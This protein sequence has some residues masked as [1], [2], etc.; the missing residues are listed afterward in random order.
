MER[1]ESSVKNVFAEMAS[2]VEKI[3]PV[4]S[5]KTAITI[6]VLG[7]ETYPK[8]TE[9]RRRNLVNRARR[10]LPLPISLTTDDQ[11][12]RI[13]KQRFRT[14]ILRQNKQLTERERLFSQVPDFVKLML[15]KDP[16]LLKNAFPE[17]YARYTQLITLLKENSV[18]DSQSSVPESSVAPYFPF[19]SQLQNYESTSNLPQLNKEAENQLLDEEYENYLKHHEVLQY[20]ASN[21]NKIHHKQYD[22]EIEGWTSQV[23][24]RNYGKPDPSIAPSKVPCSGC[25]AHLHCAATNV[26]GFMPSEKF[27]LFSKEELASQLCQRCDFLQRYNVALNVTVPADEYPKLM[28]QI[29]LNNSLV[30]ILVDLLDFPCSVWPGIVNLIGEKHSIYLVGNKV[31]LLPKDD[32][33]YLERIKKSLKE[34]LKANGIGRN[35][36]IRDVS[37]ISAKTGYGVENLVTKL[38]RDMRKGE[39]VYLIGCTN[40]GKSTLFN[41][42]MQT[43]L[44]AL[45]NAD[46]MTRATTSL[47]PGTTLNLLKFP[48]KKL[49]GWQMQLRLNRLNLYE[50]KDIAERR[51][52][53]TMY[54]QDE[55]HFP[56]LS[57]RIGATFRNNV[58]VKVEEDHPLSGYSNSQSKA[59]VFNAD[60]RKL[61]GGQWVHDTPGVI[62]KDQLLNL[63]TTEELLRTVPRELITPRTYTL[64]PGQSLF[65]GGLARVDLVQ[66]RQNIWLT[67]FASRYL[68]VNIVYTEQARKFYE[69]YLGTD[70]LAVPMGGEERLEQWPKL[71]PNELTLDCIGWEESCADVVLSNAAWAAVTGGADTRCVLRA[72]TPEGR[73]I[74]VRNPPMLP[75]AVRLRGKRIPNTP[76]FENKLFTI[77]DQT[78]G[79]IDSRMVKYNKYQTK[80]GEKRLRKAVDFVRE[81]DVTRE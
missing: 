81:S 68:P 37:L 78:S 55:S 65:V 34:S 56:I 32:K 8:L 39:D 21:L 38:L 18:N 4:N 50:K 47:W 61:K 1:P 43:D 80:I 16:N 58:P 62:F 31:D 79:A 42:L 11:I 70:M 26:P 54:R 14:S 22:L 3:A 60:S 24:L 33:F 40:S 12:G 29:Q 23:W 20:F 49:A 28:S 25:G 17:I 48:S 13:W 73:G 71:L 63:L 51:L 57:Q 66:A 45:D 59:K 6:D 36:K 19:L 44:C 75:F 9:W 76:C 72:F 41:M 64:R 46:L 35:A 5:Q 74:Y 15:E 53:W 77:D 27:T 69:L 30:V 67:V 10:V 7:E 52:Q 2:P